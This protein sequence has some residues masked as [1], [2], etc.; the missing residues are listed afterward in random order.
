M[1]S[2]H[3]EAARYLDGSSLLDPV[4][5][6]V[7]LRNINNLSELSINDSQMEDCNFKKREHFWS[8]LTCTCS[9]SIFPLICSLIAGYLGPITSQVTSQPP[10]YFCFGS[11][12]LPYP[13]N[14]SHFALIFARNF[15]LTLWSNFPAID[16]FRQQAFLLSQL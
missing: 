11:G 10:L 15:L 12:P 6:H 7:E 14:H 1:K 2:N 8:L 16:C 3:E 4:E 5:S 13:L 9:S